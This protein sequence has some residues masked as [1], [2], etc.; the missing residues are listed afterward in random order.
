MKYFG[1]RRY[2]DNSCIERK[3]TFQDILCLFVKHRDTEMSRNA[4][5]N[6]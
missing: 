6:K 3:L 2:E 4:H 1:G 5:N